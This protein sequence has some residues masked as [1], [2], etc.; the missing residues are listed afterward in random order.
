MLSDSPCSWCIAADKAQPCSSKLFLNY[1]SVQ[2]LFFSWHLAFRVR[3]DLVS[4]EA[5]DVF[6]VS[7]SPFSVMRLCLLL[8]TLKTFLEVLRR[9]G[10]VRVWD[11][12]QRD[13]VGP[14]GKEDI[15]QHSLVTKNMCVCSRRAD[16]LCAESCLQVHE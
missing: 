10:S 5:S 16:A 4:L 13:K 9:E 6:K 12:D 2:M 14:N 3:S 7:V 8:C 15:F 1:L 11:R